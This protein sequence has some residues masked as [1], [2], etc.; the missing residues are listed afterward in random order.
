MPSIFGTFFPQGPDT[1]ERQDWSPALD[2]LGR[3][4]DVLNRLFGEPGSG[5]QTSHNRD[6][7]S[8]HQ[9]QAVYQ[10]KQAWVAA[11]LE[12]EYS[13]LETDWLDWVST[14]DSNEQVADDLRK[15]GSQ[16]DLA[17]NVL[18]LG[19]LAIQLGIDELEQFYK[20]ALGRGDM[21]EAQ[22]L[23]VE[24][25]RLSNGPKDAAMNARHA[26]LGERALWQQLGDNY[27]QTN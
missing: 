19:N 27:R 4:S 3:P 17:D 15:R 16:L 22:R 9:F 8:E 1:P 10:E 6:G 5:S 14:Q 13:R 12:Q 23:A 24:A 26:Y 25:E 18:R 2:N 21:Q 11:R 7:R 20:A